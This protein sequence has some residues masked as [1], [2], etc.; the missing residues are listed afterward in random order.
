MADN[1]RRPEVPLLIHPLHNPVPWVH[2]AMLVNTAGLPLIVL[3]RHRLRDPLLCRVPL[4]R[5]DIRPS[6]PDRPRDT[7]HRLKRP[8]W[9]D[10]R[11]LRRAREWVT[12]RL[13]LTAA[14]RPNRRV[15]VKRPPPVSIR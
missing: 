2:R 6:L 8:A 3:V 13:P 4:D 12:L 15:P 14:I 1:L 10:T 5:V 7:R 9:A 11:R